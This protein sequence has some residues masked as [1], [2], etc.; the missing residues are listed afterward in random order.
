[1]QLM[2]KGLRRKGAFVGD[3]QR[4]HILER[5]HVVAARMLQPLPILAELLGDV[6]RG[7]SSAGI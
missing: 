6:P 3:D 4:H 1:L 5:L 2:I 7:L